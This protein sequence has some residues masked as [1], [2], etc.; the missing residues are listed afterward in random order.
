MLVVATKEPPALN[1]ASLARQSDSYCGNLSITS[2]LY[3]RKI[4]FYY[5]GLFFPEEKGFAYEVDT[6]A[7]ACTAVKALKGARISQVG[8][9]P[10]RLRPSPMTKWP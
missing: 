5:A 2:G 6:F 8:V 9:R 7:R 4:P 3:R 10:Q 1:D